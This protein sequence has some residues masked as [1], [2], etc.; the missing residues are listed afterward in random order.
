MNQVQNG[1]AERQGTIHEK[2][3]SS[4]DRATKSDDR[5]IQ[6]EAGVAPGEARERAEVERIPGA[7][8]AGAPDR[9]RARR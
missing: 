5:E 4:K 2:S 7:T 9:W 1:T 3:L 8:A 6:K